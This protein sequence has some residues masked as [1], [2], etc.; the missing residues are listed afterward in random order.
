MPATDS[1]DALAEQLL[2]RMYDVPQERLYDALREAIAAAI[3]AERRTQRGALV[4]LLDEYD[5]DAVQSAMARRQSWRFDGL[6]LMP[7]GGSNLPGA[8]VAEIC[9]GWLEM[10]DAEGR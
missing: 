3:R 8:L 4:L 5:R 7:D 9:R 2:D 10:Q 6:P 1:P